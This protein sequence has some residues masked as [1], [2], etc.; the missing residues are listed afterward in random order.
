MSKQP[1]MLDTILDDAEQAFTEYDRL[2]AQLRMTEARVRTL[3]RSY[4]LATGSRGVRPESLRYATATRRAT[5][6]A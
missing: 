4:D 2:R 3:C 1:T 6:P 5:S